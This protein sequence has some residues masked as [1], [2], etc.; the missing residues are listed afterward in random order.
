M[1]FIANMTSLVLYFMAVFHFDLSGAATTVTNFL[2][3]TFLLSLLG[4]FISDTYL[5]RLNTCLIFGL[6]ELLVQILRTTPITVPLIQLE[7]APIIYTSLI[8]FS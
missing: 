5:T 6:L 8:M 7:I 3:G 4:G 2:G 1:A